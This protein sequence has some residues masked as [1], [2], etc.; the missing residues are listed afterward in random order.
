[1]QNFLRIQF[2]CDNSLFNHQICLFIWLNLND[3]V[4]SLLIDYKLN[5]Q[6]LLIPRVEW[7]EQKKDCAY[8]QKW[9]VYQ[10]EVVGDQLHTR[11]QR[12]HVYPSLSCDLGHCFVTTCGKLITSCFSL[13]VSMQRRFCAVS[14][15]IKF[16]THRSGP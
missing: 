4:G 10:R 14:Y 11:L 13:L 6:P 12:I 8:L 5:L 16:I 15:I 9:T 2:S 3:T 1:M 7:Q